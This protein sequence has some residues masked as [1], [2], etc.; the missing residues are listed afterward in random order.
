[1]WYS[2]IGERIAILHCAGQDCGVGPFCM[3]VGYVQPACCGWY[4]D[5]V[6]WRDH[7]VRIWVGVRRDGISK[8]GGEDFPGRSSRYD[9]YEF[10][11]GVM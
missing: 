5:T 11:S 1:M 2:V 8:V 7:G 4:R 10:R 6:V 9:D 3:D